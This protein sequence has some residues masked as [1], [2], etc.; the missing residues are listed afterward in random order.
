MFPTEPRSSGRRV[1]SFD[2]IMDNLVMNM[3]VLSQIKNNDKISIVDADIEIHGCHEHSPMFMQ[4]LIIP[5]QRQMFG[6]GRRRTVQYITGMVSTI[7]RLC[8][9]FAS[10]ADQNE[11]WTAKKRRSVRL[12]VETMKGFIQ[13]LEQL[14]LNYI[15]DSN[16]VGK[17]DKLLA[18]VIDAQESLNKNSAFRT[19]IAEFSDK[20]L[21][22]GHSQS[23]RI[24]VP[25]PNQYSSQR[26]L[27]PPTQAQH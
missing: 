1:P 11:Q 12:F 22:P 8:D 13:G 15:S 21:S 20:K 24:S 16:V 6:Q 4:S 27:H 18:E 19:M 17:L 23:A 25:Q 7:A 10:E 9:Q 2:D 26:P 5:L 3:S 14:R